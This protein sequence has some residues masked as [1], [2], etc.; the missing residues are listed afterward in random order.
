MQLLSGLCAGRAGALLTAT[1]GF[2]EF[3]HRR[4]CMPVRRH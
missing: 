4:D 2:R 3:H 1:D